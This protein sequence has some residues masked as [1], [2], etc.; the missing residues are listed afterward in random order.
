MI[1]MLEFNL[2]RNILC[3]SNLRHTRNCIDGRADV[4]MIQSLNNIMLYP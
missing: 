4:S 2:C 1:A 3:D